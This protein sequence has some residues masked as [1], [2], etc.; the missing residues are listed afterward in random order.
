MLFVCI[1]LEV[2]VRA[3]REEKRR[4]R[5]R[6]IREEGFPGGSDRKESNC[7]VGDLGLIPGWGRS[8]GGHGSPLQF[9]CLQNPHGQRSLAGCGPWGRKESDMTEQ[10]STSEKKGGS[11]Y[12]YMEAFLLIPLNFLSELKR[13]SEPWL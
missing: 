1:I 10:L 12:L 2:L 8:G 4:G 3:L 6:G 11:F 13:V 7:N 5:E 9:S